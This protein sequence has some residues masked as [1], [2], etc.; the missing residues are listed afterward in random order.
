MST[1]Q[2]RLLSY[3][4][5]TCCYMRWLNCL[6][7]WY[8]RRL[9]N[10]HR[11]VYYY[12]RRIVLAR[13]WKSRRGG[14]YRHHVVCILYQYFVS[15]VMNTSRKKKD[16]TAQFREGQFAILKCFPMKKEGRASSSY[17]CWKELVLYCSTPLLH[18]L[19]IWLS[20]FLL[21]NNR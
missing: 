7:N 13:F 14:I 12:V 3:V 1:E 20:Y 6:M 21:S 11:P 17:F 18:I 10:L 2:K 5:H 4:I 15:T 16:T 8:K 9:V 19:R